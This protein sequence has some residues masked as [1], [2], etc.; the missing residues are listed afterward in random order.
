MR[1]SAYHDGQ[2]GAGSL[3]IAAM[4]IQA[5]RGPPGGGC[6][7]AGAPA[8]CSVASPRPSSAAAPGDG[9]P[10]STH[11]ITSH[12]SSWPSTA[13]T[14][15]AAAS[16]SHRSDAASAATG[17]CLTTTDPPSASTTRY[18]EPP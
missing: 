12:S 18:T 6:P 9:E 7:N 4:P 16:A 5:S 11:S 13:G 14:G 1:Y 2:S 8:R 10:G 15:T 3:T 17:P